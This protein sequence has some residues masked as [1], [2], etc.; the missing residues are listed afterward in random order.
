MLS[1]LIGKCY[2]KLFCSFLINYRSNHLG[3]TIFCYTCRAA[4]QPGNQGNQGEVSESNFV[5]DIQGKVR[6]FSIFDQKS[7][8]MGKS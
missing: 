2:S 5:S 7:G 1:Y 6:E 8:K 4:S 3:N